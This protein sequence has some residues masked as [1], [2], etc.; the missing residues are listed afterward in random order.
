MDQE[1]KRL[2]LDTLKP[3]EIDPEF[4]PYLERINRLPFVVTK[5]CCIGHMEY[6]TEGQ[7]LPPDGSGRWGYL[8]LLLHDDAA[9]W[10]HEGRIGD[11]EW[12]W[13]A[14]SQLWVEGAGMPGITDSGSFDIVFAWD[15]KHWPK[16]AE[17]ICEALEEF[18]RTWKR[19]DD[20]A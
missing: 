17:D 16:P 15:A 9:T 19:S 4:L 5:Q 18:G 8:E 1:D 12:L 14:G 3:E 7:Y 2:T 20:L 13:V 10:L 6:K 11:W